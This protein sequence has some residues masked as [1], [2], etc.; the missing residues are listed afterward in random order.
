MP[1]V[2]IPSLMS[3]L[4]PF[5]EKVTVPGATV[6]QVIDQ[7]EARF[8]GIRE[9]LCQDGRLLSNIAVVVDGAISQQRLSHP[10]NETSQVR[11][12]PA[13]SGG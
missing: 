10:L 7:L 2:V 3:D 5:V 13:L 4:A 12:I 9:R 11:F 8:P 1:I 6:R